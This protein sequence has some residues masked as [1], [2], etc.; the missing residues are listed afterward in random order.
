M[1]SAPLWGHAAPVNV[2]LYELGNELDWGDDAIT[3]ET[4]IA[5]CKEFISAVKAA[6][7]NA[8]FAAHANTAAYNGVQNNNPSDWREWHRAILADSDLVNEIDYISVHAYYSHCKNEI[9]DQLI[10]FVE[11]D[12]NASAGANRIKIFLS[13]YAESVY[14]YGDQTTNPHNMEGVLQTA[15]MLS[16]MTYHTGIES[17]TYHGIYSSHWQNVVY[18]SA[19]GKMQLNAIGNLLKMFTEYGVGDILESTFTGFEKDKR[20]SGCN[21]RCNPYRGRQN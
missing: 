19:T 17:A 6:D 7:P 2:R 21:R 15:D 13:E 4:Y 18:G 20:S 1:Q 12:I 11:S 3:V 8:R 14:T 9:M 10:G 16:R 5:K